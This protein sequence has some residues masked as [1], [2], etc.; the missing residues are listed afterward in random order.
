MIC[1][2]V[3]ASECSA[4]RKTIGGDGSEHRGLSATANTNIFSLASRPNNYHRP[5]SLVTDL[6]L[7]YENKNYL[8]SWLAHSLWAVPSPSNFQFPHHCLFHLLSKPFV[9]HN[10]SPTRFTSSMSNNRFIQSFTRVPKE[11]FRLNTGPTIRLRAQPGPVRPQRSFDLLTEAGK[12][13][14]LALN[15]ATYECR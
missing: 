3:P 12:V 5:P 4:T 7:H 13:R 10:T 14:P 2:W 11:L 9:V 8:N 6:L 15:P 1:L